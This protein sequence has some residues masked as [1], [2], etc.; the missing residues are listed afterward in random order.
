M[1]NV[2]LSDV[3]VTKNEYCYSIIKYFDAQIGCP[4]E[5]RGIDIA[6]WVPSANAEHVKLIIA[7]FSFHRTKIDLV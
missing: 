7:R 5:D 2:E 4:I 1:N 6:H 3:L